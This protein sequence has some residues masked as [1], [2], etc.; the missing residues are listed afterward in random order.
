MALLFE[1]DENNHKNRIEISDMEHLQVIYQGVYEKTKVRKLRVERVNLDGKDKMFHKKIA[2]NG[3]DMWSPTTEGE[4]QINAILSELKSV[5]D[6][7]L[8]VKPLQIEDFDAKFNYEFSN[9]ELTLTM[10]K[11][12]FLE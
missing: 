5:I 8:D 1:F 9:I 3:E 4:L 11:F 10:K 2:S 6:S 7:G 12:E